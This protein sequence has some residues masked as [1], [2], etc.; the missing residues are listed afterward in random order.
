MNTDRKAGFW[1]V[2]ILEAIFGGSH[3]GK[4]DFGCYLTT[5]AGVEYVRLG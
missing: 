1:D 4:P 5:V 3:F 2:I